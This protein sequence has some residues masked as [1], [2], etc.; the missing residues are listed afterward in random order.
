MK[1]IP[2]L[3]FKPEDFVRYP[4]HA[5]LAKD[6]T[7]PAPELISEL[8]AIVKTGT[9]REIKI[10]MENAGYDCD[11]PGVAVMFMAIEPTTGDSLMHTA[12]A[13]QRPDAMDALRHFRTHNAAYYDNPFYALYTHQNHAGDTILHVAARSGKLAVVAAAFQVFRHEH[14]IL[15][16]EKLR[17]GQD[18]E[19]HMWDDDNEEAYHMRIG[20]VLFLV[21]QNSEGRTA[22]DE[23]RA[24][25][26]GDIVAWLERTVKAYDTKGESSDPSILQL[27]QDSCNEYYGLP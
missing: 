12:A 2:S 13:A 20:G 21:R 3:P 19:G 5:C 17:S 24:L 18:A 4:E 15:D 25:G 26:F 16:E 1:R 27:W 7:A 9:P 23:A 6:A 22:A 8:H 14:L 11:A 10:A